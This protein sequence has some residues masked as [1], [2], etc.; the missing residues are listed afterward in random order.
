MDSLVVAFLDI[1]AFL[2]CAVILWRCDP[3]INRMG[4][5][6]HGL[7][8]YAFLLLIAGALAELV[9]LLF[10]GRTPGCAEAVILVGTALLLLCERRIRYLAR[11]PAKRVSPRKVCP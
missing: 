5:H 1:L 7:I 8:R 4:R 3:A 2:S 9:G 11:Q 6:T 10:F